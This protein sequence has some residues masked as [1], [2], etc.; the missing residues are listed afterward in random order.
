MEMGVACFASLTSC[1]RYRWLDPVPIFK[2]LIA[3]LES[4]GALDMCEL[5][6]RLHASGRVL[7]SIPKIDK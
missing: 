1:V 7:Y 3:I 6:N 4:G 5:Y 2:I